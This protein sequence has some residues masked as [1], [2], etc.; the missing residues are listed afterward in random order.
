VNNKDQVSQA[1]ET[2]LDQILKKKFGLA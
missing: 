1:I 2:V